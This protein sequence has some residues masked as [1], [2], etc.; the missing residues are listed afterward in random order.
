[1]KTTNKYKINN[2]PIL[3]PTSMSINYTRQAKTADRSES[4]IYDDDR[5]ADGVD[6]DIAFR[7]RSWD[8]LAYITSLLSTGQYITFTYRSP[9]TAQFIN[10]TMYVGDRS[11]NILNDVED[12]SFSSFD[13][14]AHLV[15]KN[16]DIEG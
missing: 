3:A 16:S 10:Q 12:D 4:G 13:V 8:E 15:A 2:K 14:T 9:K 7:P 1:M 6:M 11:I 5:I